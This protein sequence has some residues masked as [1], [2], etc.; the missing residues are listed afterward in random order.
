MGCFLGDFFFLPILTPYLKIKKLLQCSIRPMFSLHVA[1]FVI[2]NDLGFYKSSHLIIRIK[3]LGG[4][5][6]DQ[7][8]T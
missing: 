2:H 6:L 4:Q 1:N 3:P 5:L 7:L 8:F